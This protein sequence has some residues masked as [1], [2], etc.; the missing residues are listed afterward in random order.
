LT[1]SKIVTPHALKWQKKK[2]EERES[3]I[4]LSDNPTER[5]IKEKKVAL[6]D[7]MLLNNTQGERR[8]KE[9][10]CHLMRTTYT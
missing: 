9:K 4:A 2:K 7:T 3:K 6:N 10:K 5:E 1:K 8:L